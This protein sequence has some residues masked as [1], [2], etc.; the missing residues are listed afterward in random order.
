MCVSDMKLN[1]SMIEADQGVCSESMWMWSSWFEEI[2][3]IAGN[4]SGLS[5]CA[6]GSNNKTVSS[7]CQLAIRSTFAVFNPAELILV[8]GGTNF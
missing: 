1:F 4:C 8:G 5:N 2:I 3:S 6:Q 7:Y